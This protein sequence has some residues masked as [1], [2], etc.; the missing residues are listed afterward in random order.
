[1]RTKAPSLIS[2]R[3]SGYYAFTGLD[4]SRPVIG[5]DDGKKQPLFTLNNAHSKWTGTVVRDTGLKVRKRIDEGEI[6]HQNFF[7]RTGLAYAVQTGKS[8]NLHTERSA[9]YTDAFT[10]DAPVTSAMF[11]GKLMFMSAGHGMIMT[12]GFSFMPNTASVTPG[13]GV[14][15]QNRMY[16]AGIPNKPT[17]IEISRLF[18]NDGD[19]QIFLAEETA[20]TTSTRA[21]FLDLTN[22][23]GTADEI[24]G[25]ARFETNRLAI[26]TNDQA[27]I[28]KVDPDIANF[29][30]DTRANVQL[31]SISH[32]S[33]AQVGSD[34][35]FCSRHGVHSLIRSNDNGITIDTRTLSFEIE[36]VYKDLLRKCI[37]PR[38]VSSTYDQDLGRLHIFFPMADGL[39][40]ALVAEFRRGYEALS[41]STSDIGSARCG[42][43]LA[44][45]MTFGTTLTMYDRLDELFELSPLDD[46]TDDFI[47]PAMVI[48]TPILWHGQ[49]DELK[50]ARALVVQ[51]AGTGTLRITAHDEEGNEV[52]VEEIQVERRDDNP[53]S[54]PSDALDVQFRIP[55]QLRYRGIQLKFESTDMGDLEL[56]GFAIEL[57]TPQK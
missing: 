17:E 10:R 31:G 21:D 20:T 2:S 19:E 51:A 32:N 54:F 12:D 24:T 48:E 57:K 35:I 6:V 29:E 34:I 43:F 28:Y 13:F 53:V 14:A 22:I 38:F 7:N 40:K 16:V 11:A 9:S 37:G 1:M 15:I 50:E 44:G 42:A 8:I 49:I 47:R 33:I 27:I 46:L 45:S 4:R 5:M 25:L 23:I 56:L 3:L 41:W 55:F 18:N 39:H 52:L 36:E 26:F 30:I